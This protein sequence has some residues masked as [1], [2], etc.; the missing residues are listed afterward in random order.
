MA[1]ECANGCSDGQEF[2]D[3]VAASTASGAD[4]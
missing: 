3:D 2:G 1:G 4:D